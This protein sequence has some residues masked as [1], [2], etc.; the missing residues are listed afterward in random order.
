M[1]NVQ[2]KAN[3]RTELG[4][5]AMRRARKSGKIPG[6]VYAAGE[7]GG[8]PLFF[9][10]VELRGVLRRIAGGV[11]IVTL[12]IDGELRPALLAEC[13]RNLLDDK[14]L[15]VDFNAISMKKKMHAHLP[16]T[17]TGVEDCVGVKSEN[18]VLEFLCHSFEIRC[19]PK[20]LPSG[21]SVDVSQLHV[22]QIIHVKDLQQV[23]GVQILS[24]PELV[25][26]VCSAMK[27]AEEGSS[28]TA[29]AVA[30]E[31]ADDAKKD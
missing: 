22:G 11:A 21:Y 10:D 27:A 31:T 28:A 15:H 3:K 18:G 14:L 23:D 26:V 13:Q 6:V 2:L 20:D 1:K 16:V 29:A 30:A 7:V 5:G 19:F 9:D 8:I 25:I 17:L 4:R 12:D 24:P